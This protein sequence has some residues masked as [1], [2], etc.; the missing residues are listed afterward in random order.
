MTTFHSEP[1]N[2]LLVAVYPGGLLLTIN[3]ECYFKSMTYCQMLFMAEELVHRSVMELKRCGKE[4][5]R[6]TED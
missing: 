4:E 2:Q 6:H 1:D 3:G 5:A